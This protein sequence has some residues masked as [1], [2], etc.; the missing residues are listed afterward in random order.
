M[1]HPTRLP[2]FDDGNHFHWSNLQLLAPPH[3]NSFILI[4]LFMIMFRLGLC[5]AST[6]LVTSDVSEEKDLLE[7][8]IVFVNRPKRAIV[9]AQEQ[10]D[11]ER[12][13]QSFL[14]AATVSTSSASHQQSS[15]LVHSYRSIVTGF[16]ARVTAAEA[17]DM[18]LKQGFV[19]AWPER[20]LQVHTTHTPAFLGLH[21]NSGF[22]DY[23]NY[24]EGVIIG[25]IDTGVAPDHTSFNDEGMPPPPA[26]WKGRC[27]F[28][29]SLSCNNKLI[30]ARNFVP[31]ASQPLDDNGHG[32]H[33]S[34]TA[35]GSPVEGASFY[36][37]VN[38]TAVGMAPKA[39]LA[40]YKAC[41]ASGHCRES[42]VLAAMDTAVEDGVDVLSLSLGYGSLPFHQDSVAIGAFGAIQKGVFVTCSAGNSGPRLSSLSNEAPWILTVGASTVDRSV[43]ATV[44]LG[45]MN[46]EIHGESYFQPKDF[47]STMLPL[48]YA[49]S[50]RNASFCQSGSLDEFDVKG[51]V[52]LCDNYEEFNAVAQGQAVKD[53]GGAAMI[54]ASDPSE[55]LIPTPEFHVLP[56]S[57]I[58]SADGNLT[59]SYINS[60]SSSPLATIMFQGTVLGLPYAPQVSLSS[61]RG[62]SSAS[63]GILK[64]DILGPGYRILAAWPESM[65]NK[66]NTK[67]TFNVIS[68]TSMACPHLAGIAAL[69]KSS[70]PDWSPAAIKS[71]I[72]TTADS[73]N[74]AGDPITDVR[75]VKADLFATGSGQ[76]N[77]T[78]ANDPGFIYDIQPDDYIRYLCGLGYSD[79]LVEIIVQHKVS[80]SQNLS[81]PEAQLNY[82][83]FSITL[84]STTR[85]Y[86]R[87][88]T[89]VGAANSSY[90]SEIL[91]LQ[92]V[93]VKVTPASIVFTE[94]NQKASYSV[95]F[96]KEGSFTRP[97]AHG[98]LRWVSND[99][100]VTSPIAVKFE[101]Q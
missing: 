80:C 19:S 57:H 48:F 85:S 91:G 82:P 14:P 2:D 63:P 51:K 21:Q 100:N 7:T 40:V 30:G 28:N 43:R 20:M 47:A 53:A 96:S 31:T 70:H 95:T 93:Y 6:E 12:W 15:R 5:Q 32:T 23:S 37:Q 87:T 45:N 49:G 25:V 1:G 4:I 54:L 86:T 75:F 89:N 65:D 55:D 26:K 41:F 52:V 69:L 13:Y 24:G 68:G 71:A 99:H 29:A 88:V 62:P 36:G 67:S 9:N 42:D 101:F 44:R 16:A 34:S 92:G 3:S 22:W 97:S 61:S 94:V 79:T 8:Y 78:K 59:K 18:E 84:S 74:L 72:M 39:H 90:R 33:T 38:G 46:T 27:E 77:P 81:I 35:A 50:N 60:S 73:A 66:N 56:A 11:L 83:S 98:Y 76:V 10:Q 17:K 58:S 64:P